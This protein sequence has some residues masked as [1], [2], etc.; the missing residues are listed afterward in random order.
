MDMLYYTEN[1][2]VHGIQE[3]LEN[4]DLDQYE[5]NFRVNGFDNLDFLVSTETVIIHECN[6]TRNLDEIL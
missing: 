4:L 5:N 2:K 1:Q 6:D 3:W